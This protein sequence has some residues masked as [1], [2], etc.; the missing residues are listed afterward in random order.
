[1]GITL[2]KLYQ[3]I[4]NI[5]F[6]RFPWERIIDNFPLAH[7]ILFSY[8]SANLM[9]TSARQVI[10]LPEFAFIHRKHTPHDLQ[11]HIA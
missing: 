11:T 8:D 3:E 2:H 9:L 7:E 6:Q 1:M 10:F 4:I 5:L